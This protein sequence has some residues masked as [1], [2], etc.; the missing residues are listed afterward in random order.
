MFIYFSVYNLPREAFKDIYDETL[1]QCLLCN[2]RIMRKLD[3]MKKHFD[4]KHPDFCEVLVAQN[5]GPS[6]EVKIDVSL[7]PNMGMSSFF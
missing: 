6:Q 5:P 2:E 4:R 3:T 7:I 1:Q